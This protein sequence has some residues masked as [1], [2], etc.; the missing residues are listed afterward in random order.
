MSANLY[1]LLI[2]S[3]V[4]VL[5]VLTIGYC[6]LLN[7]RLSKLRSNEHSF[8][9]TISELITA[10]ENAERAI[11][12]LK[13]AVRESNESLGDRLR[14]SETVRLDLEKELERGE[15][16]LARIMRIASAADEVRARTP[17][18]P[19]PRPQPQHDTFQSIHAE[20]IARRHAPDTMA[21]AQA[22]AERTRRRAAA[23]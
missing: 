10:T 9:V 7:R 21:A 17:E 5:L 23:A 1:G 22:L 11:A 2:E 14:S 3:L 20:M 12:G 8:K 15:G 13:M 6:M 16:V 18:P 4:A 19:R